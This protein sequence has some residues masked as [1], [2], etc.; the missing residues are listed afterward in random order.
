MD[1]SKYS[2]VDASEEAGTAETPKPE[3]AE[4]A[5]VDEEEEEKNKMVLIVSI[6]AICLLVLLG[7]IDSFTTKYIHTWSQQL[8][9]WTFDNAPGSFFVLELVIFIFIVLCIPYGLL[10][11]LS[12]AVFYKK[13]GPNGIWMG[14]LALFVSTFAA[15]SVCFA[16]ARY[17]FRNTVK[18]MIDKSPNVSSAASPAVS[19]FLL[20]HPRRRH[21]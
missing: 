19:A 9:D 12:G 5:D 14:G 16:L 17:K 3:G 11:V 4:G 7:A 13:Y 1:M 8:G 2:K 20:S 15:G 6:A 21:P 18:R 10:A